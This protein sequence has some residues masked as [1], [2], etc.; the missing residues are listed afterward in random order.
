[1]RLSTFVFAFL[2]SAMSF[3][4]APKKFTVIGYY[5]GNAEKVDSLAAEKLTAIYL[6]LLSPEREST[7][8]R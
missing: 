2:V 6:Q 5:S 3:A 7:R 4:Q 1:M 8:C